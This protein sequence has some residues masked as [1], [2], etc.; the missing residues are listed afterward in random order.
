MVEIWKDIEGF[1]GFYQISNLGRVKSLERI[2]DRPISGKI[3]Y[4]EKILNVQL[5]KKR[6]YV[7]IQLYKNGYSRRYIVHRLVAEAFIPNPNNLPQ[8]NH[9]DE[10][11]LNNCVDNLEWCTAKYNLTY[12]TRIERIAKK[13]YV[14]VIAYNDHEEFLFSSQTDGAKQL[15]VLQS[16]IAH[17]LKNNRYTCGGYHWKYANSTK[18]G[19]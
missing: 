17:C 16:N 5:N 13:N 19:D 4:T 15:N 9:K 3:K 2:I 11:S 10:N 1:E 18:A 14:P 12:G 8:V 7:Y 6:N